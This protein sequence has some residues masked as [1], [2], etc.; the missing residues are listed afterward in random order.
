MSNVK[1]YPTS[2]NERVIIK[3]VYFKEYKSLEAINLLVMLMNEYPLINSKKDIYQLAGGEF[4]FSC[5]HY[6]DGFIFEG[7]LIQCKSKTLKFMFFN[8]YKEA[9]NIFFNVMNNGFIHDEKVLAHCKDKISKLSDF[10]ISSLSLGI[11]IL[12]FP[13]SDILIDKN[14][15]IEVTLD[16]VDSVFQVIKNSGLGEV[17]YIGNEGNKLP[18]IEL[19]DKPTL[20]YS[21]LEQKNYKNMD[22]ETCFFFFK[23]NQ[24]KSYNN[25]NAYYLMISMLNKYIQDKLAN[26]VF[27]E[28]SLNS[29]LLD[30]S[31]F[32]ISISTE[33]KKLFSILQYLDFSSISLSS[34]YDYALRM[35]EI[36][37]IK[38]MMDSSL[39]IDDIIATNDLKLTSSNSKM[40]KDDVLS[41]VSK[42][43]FE[44]KIVFNED[45]KNA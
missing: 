42:V 30:D 13:Y 17:I 18:S 38:E 26:K 45:N 41:Y 44:N 6:N 15:L 32:A 11:K 25:K 9:E 20:K 3:R 22:D 8:P 21:L 35:E 2:F 1:S 14:K 36:R 40:T 12:K 31:H 5:Y 19:K 29:F 27:I 28:Y 16:D 39:I 4:K 34:Y 10:D 43:E 37:K 23:T 7:R 33:N 24:I